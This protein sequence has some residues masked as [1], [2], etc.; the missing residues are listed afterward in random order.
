IPDKRVFVGGNYSFGSRLEDIADAIRDCE[1]IPIIALEFGIPIGTT[2][3]SAEQIIKQCKYG[4]FEVSSAAGQFFEMEDAKHYSLITLC[5]WDAYQGHLSEM[6][7]T[8]IVFTN[9]NRAYRNTRELH[10]QVYDFLR[11]V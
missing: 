3:H 8:H 9:N 4:I 6:L 7:S 10:H 5:L 2:R 1:F 11:N